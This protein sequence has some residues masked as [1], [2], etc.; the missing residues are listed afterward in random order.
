MIEYRG[1]KFARSGDNY[2]VLKARISCGLQRKYPTY[3]C[4]S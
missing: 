4:R 1:E 2:N 3:E